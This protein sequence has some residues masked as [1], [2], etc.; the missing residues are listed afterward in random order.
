[1]ARPIVQ[2]MF[3]TNPKEGD[4]V[5][6]FINMEVEPDGSLPCYAHMGQHAGACLEYI[7][8]NC[9]PS[10][11][12]ERDELLAELTAIYSDCELVVRQRRSAR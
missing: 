9:R 1:M 8:G 12:A 5:A 4:V 2:V 3:R 10:T 7:Y 11:T 6:V